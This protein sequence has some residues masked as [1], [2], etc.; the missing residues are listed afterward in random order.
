[1]TQ[2][3]LKMGSFQT[4]YVFVKKQDTS[5]MNKIIEQIRTR[6]NKW[7]NARQTFRE[8]YNLS[9]RELH[10]IGISRHDIASMLK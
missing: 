7:Q 9:D 8:L 4:R 2:M 6:Y 5:K 3:A 10:D 1:M